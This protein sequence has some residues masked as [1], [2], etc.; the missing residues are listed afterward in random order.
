MPRSPIS[1]DTGR[2]SPT[3]GNRRALGLEAK[4]HDVAQAYADV[5][6]MFG[7]IVKVTPTSKGRRQLALSMSGGSSVEIQPDVSF[8]SGPALPAAISA[9]RR[10]MAEGAP[11]QDPQG[12]PASRPGSL[13]A[14]API[15]R[16]CAPTP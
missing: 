15:S 16:R 13:M 11:D 2:S 7:D 4:W 1:T 9:N 12:Q 14:D 10:G 5:N 6:R 3:S 8:P